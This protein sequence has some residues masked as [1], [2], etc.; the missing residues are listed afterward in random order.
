[1]VTIT[2]EGVYFTLTEI[3]E[4]GLESEKVIN[5][6]ESSLGLVSYLTFPVELEEGIT[7][8]HIMNLLALN[9]EHTDFMFDSSLGGHQFKSFYEELQEDAKP[10]ENLSYME[11]AHELDVLTPDNL[12]LFSVARMRGVGK[13]LELF[14]IEFAPLSTYKKFEIRLNQDFIVKKIDDSNHESVVLSCKKSFTLFDV[15]HAV[16]FE[17]SYYGGPEE[18]NKVLNEILGSLEVDKIDAFRLS[19]KDDIHSLR[20]RLKDLIDEE[21]YE[22]AAKVRDKINELL[23]DKGEENKGA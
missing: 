7:V 6:L 16:L 5:V 22:E 21:D 4:E 11:I 18:R 1:M 19:N 2:K 8:E 20:K 13:N 14:S 10:D 15:I 12:D 3:N 17:M 23:N 9:M